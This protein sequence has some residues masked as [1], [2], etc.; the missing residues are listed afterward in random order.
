MNSD[1]EIAVDR[2]L[3]YQTQLLARKYR[4]NLPSVTQQTLAYCQARDIVA[5]HAVERQDPII[6]PNYLLAFCKVIDRW[7]DQRL[8]WRTAKELTLEAADA[9]NPKFLFSDLATVRIDHEWST[10]SVTDLPSV[11]GWQGHEP[12]WEWI[13]A[14]GTNFTGEG[15]SVNYVDAHAQA[16]FEMQREAMT[17]FQWPNEWVKIRIPTT[18]RTAFSSLATTLRLEY[19]TVLVEEAETKKKLSRMAAEMISMGKFIEENQEALEQER[20]ERRYLREDVPARM[21]RWRAEDELTAA[22]AAPAVARPA[23]KDVEIIEHL[24]LQAHRR[25]PIPRRRQV[26]EIDYSDGN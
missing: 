1:S 17:Q 6:I 20:E 24:P 16:Y 18:R 9:A 4:E 19:D 21:E 5:L 25:R 2:N 22:P 7:R 13:T 15:W 11:T 14:K 12:W 3:T 10:E 8:F 26:I 23:S